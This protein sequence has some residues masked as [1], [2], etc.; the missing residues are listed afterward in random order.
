MILIFNFLLKY[1]ANIQANSHTIFK[2][3]LNK[4]KFV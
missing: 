4:S 3:I 2:S 1:L